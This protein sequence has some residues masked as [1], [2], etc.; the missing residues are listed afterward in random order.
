MVLGNSAVA[1]RLNDP[2]VKLPEADTLL[3]RPFAN[4]F[5]VLKKKPLS[6]TGD[7]PVDNTWAANVADLDAIDPA[8]PVETEGLIGETVNA[9]ATTGAA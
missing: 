8:S 6:R 4:P 9:L 2:A 3:P 7:P 5:V 1:F